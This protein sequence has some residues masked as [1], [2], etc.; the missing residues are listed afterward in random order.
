[1]MI[2]SSAKYTLRSNKDAPFV[3][4]H[5]SL[6]PTDEA[7]LERRKNEILLFLTTNRMLLGVHIPG[8][9]QVL[10]PVYTLKRKLFLG[11]YG[12]TT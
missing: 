7:L 8:L 5:S 11:D 9:L 2:H 4:N 1:M 10:S 3:M 12:A 6:S